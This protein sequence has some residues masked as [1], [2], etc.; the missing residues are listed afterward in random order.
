VEDGEKRMTAGEWLC[1]RNASRDDQ[2]LACGALIVAELRAAV[3][4]ETQFTCSAG[5]AHNKMLAKLTSSMHKP[6]QQT[7]VPSSYVPALLASI[8]IKKIGQ[9]GGKLGKS[10][11]ED[12][13]VTTAADLLPF[14]EIKL[15]DLYGVNTGTWLWNVARGRS[16]DKVQGRVL[17]KSHSCSKTFAGPK[18]LKDMASVMYWLGEMAEELQERLDLDLENNN[19]T[20]RLLVFHAACHLKGRAQS[21]NRKFPSKSCALRYGKDKIVADA[22]VLFEKCLQDFCPSSSLSPLKATGG[23]SCNWAVTALSVGASNISALPSRVSPITSF[24]SSPARHSSEEARICLSPPGSP[25]SSPSWTPYSLT[26]E[27]SHLRTADGASCCESSDGKRQGSKPADGN[28]TSTVDPPNQDLGSMQDSRAETGKDDSNEMAANIEDEPTSCTPKFGTV[29]SPLT[30]KVEFQVLRGHIPAETSLEVTSQKST[31]N[32]GGTAVLEATPILCSPVEEDPTF[33][34][35]PDGWFI[36]TVEECQGEAQSPII[37]LSVEDPT[38]SIAPDE[39]FIDTV[40]ECQG[41][42][43]PDGEILLSEKRPNRVN[44]ITSA[45]SAARLTTDERRRFSRD[46]QVRNDE[47]ELQS[48]AVVATASSD[49]NA[50]A[51]SRTQC[52]LGD[53]ETSMDKCPV[54]AKVTTGSGRLQDLW[55]AKSARSV[56]PKRVQTFSMEWEYKHE[57]IDEKVLLELPLEIQRELRSSLRLKRPRPPKRTSISDFFQSHSSTSKSPK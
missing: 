7:V 22:R 6:A 49:I 21:T 41:E 35:D 44:E 48:E 40:Q 8:P 42:A 28:E 56:S 17:P 25:T 52:M 9:L 53:Q 29:G 32:A 3:L 57:E 37:D 47:I 36:N 51:G 23:T 38:F 46:K 1:Q 55:Q 54:I 30:H 31:L 10:L 27:E 19:R 45:T 2:L 43:E 13:G 33:S 11:K 20:A 16:G 14:P 4:Q 34:I 50:E 12:L 26:D 15:Q 39:Q 24:F 5:I 18:S